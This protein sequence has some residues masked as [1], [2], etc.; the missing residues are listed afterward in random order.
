[1][2]LA[3]CY[4]SLRKE[5]SYQHFDLRIRTLFLKIAGILTSMATKLTVLIPRPP[6]IFILSH[7]F[8]VHETHIMPKYVYKIYFRCAN[9]KLRLTFSAFIITKAL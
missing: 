5:G 3:G 7:H 6:C 8:E 2:I 9:G 4:R 1:M